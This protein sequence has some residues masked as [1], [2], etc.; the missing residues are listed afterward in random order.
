[1]GRSFFF[2][3]VVSRVAERDGVDSSMFKKIVYLNYFMFLSGF[4]VAIL[5]V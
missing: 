1:M 4:K 2:L 5:A 3:V